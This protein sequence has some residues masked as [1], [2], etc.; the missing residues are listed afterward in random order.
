MATLSNKYRD[1]VIEA[2]LDVSAF[3]AVADPHVALY[4]SEP[5]RD[6]SG[7]ELSGDGYARQEFNG[8]A[9]VDGEVT[10]NADIEFGPATADWGE[11]THMA[12]HDGSDPATSE[13]VMFGALE[14]SRNVLEDDFLRFS[15]DNISVTVDPDA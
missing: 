10:N 9:A 15:E 14:T 12:I 3:D 5:G 13:L 1:E 11:V 4:T 6:D 7:T 8:T 2:L